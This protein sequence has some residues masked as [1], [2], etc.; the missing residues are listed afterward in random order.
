MESA[1]LSGNIKPDTIVAAECCYGAQLYDHVMVNRRQPI[2]LSYLENGAI[3]FVGSTNIAYGPADTNGAADLIA[4]LFWINLLKGLS[5][6]R[7]LLQA[8]QQF[9]QREKMSDPVNL[10]TIAQ[11]LLLGDASLHPCAVKDTAEAT[12]LTEAIDPATQRK[13][14]RAALVNNGQAVAATASALGRAV[15]SGATAHRQVQDRVRALAKGQGLE[16]PK[17]AT[18][19]VSGG[20]ASRHGAKALGG[21]APFVT[22]AVES[23][24]HDEVPHMP[25][26]QV[27]VAHSLYD[28]GE[29][30]IS[31]IRAYVSR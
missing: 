22:V 25:D 10:K 31:S 30:E 6:G 11:F 21:S 2:C 1:R 28:D 14:A 16:N 20:R 18:Y 4:Q 7:A 15:A 3:G 8:R 29:H 17:V 23:K 5:L 12:L 19:H 24:K 26:V 27:I 9:I 13:S